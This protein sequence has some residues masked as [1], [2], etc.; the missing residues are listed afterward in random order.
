[1]P[2]LVMDYIRRHKDLLTNKGIMPIIHEIEEKR[3]EYI[4]EKEREI[5]YRPLGDSSDEKEWLEL[6]AFL[7]ALKAERGE[8][9]Q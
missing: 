7:K 9:Q 5:G 3:D 4:T 6:L 8:R 1:M 2:K